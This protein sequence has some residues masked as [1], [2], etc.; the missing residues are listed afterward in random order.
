[1]ESTRKVALAQLAPVWLNRTAT[2]DKIM[3]AVLEAAEQ[4]ATL[5]AFGESLLPGYPFLLFRPA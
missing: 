2:L 4:G 1:M 3:Q 5:V